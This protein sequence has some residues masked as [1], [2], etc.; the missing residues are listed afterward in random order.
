VTGTRSSDGLL[1][2]DPGDRFEREA[3]A[4]AARIVCGPDGG[5]DSRLATGSRQAGRP[6]GTAA[7]R[8][9]GRAW[10]GPVVQRLIGT[11]GQPAV[12]K[13]AKR[14]IAKTPAYDVVDAKVENGTW[15]YLLRNPVGLQLDRWVGQ[16][17]EYDL[18]DP[19]VRD[20]ARQALHDQISQ[21]LQVAP[22][23]TAADLLG[24]DL[25]SRVALGVGMAEAEPSKQPVRVLWSGGAADCVIIAAIG[26]NGG[27]IAHADR[28]APKP[29]TIA[30]QVKA[31]GAMRVYLA[32]SIFASGNAGDSELVRGIMTQL[33]SKGVTITAIYPYSSL[34]VDVTT[35][36]LRANLSQ[37]DRTLLATGSG[38]QA[39]TDAV[40]AKRHQD[41]QQ[42]P[43]T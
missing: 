28:Q 17:E 16:D 23:G 40:E 14:T 15:R 7:V 21:L 30:T 3:E 32:S 31:T 13:R 41:K 19:L 43:P 26:G 2:S 8:E 36:A 1:V 6:P 39:L 29:D 25:P 18:V 34:A 12:G 5:P 42:Q 27:W 24:A 10:G 9:A 20:T 4:V 38:Y 37:T 22:A 11:V 35:G 33:A